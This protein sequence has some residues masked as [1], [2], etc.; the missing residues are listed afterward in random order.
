MSTEPHNPTGATRRQLLRT[1]A[2]GF[3]S[4][5]LSGMLGGKPAAAGSSAS[6]A[7]SQL[8]MFAPRA[9]RV[10]FLFMQGGP[11]QVD[12]FDYKPLL[13]KHH[14]E[15]LSFRDDRKLAK[16]GESGKEIVMRSPWR[17]TRAGESGK[18]VS[19]LFPHVAKCVDQLCFLH[20][21]HTN[22]VAHGPSTLFL[23]TGAID[24]VR[25]SVGS[26]VTYGL[27]SEC[28]NLPGFIT[29]GPPATNGGPRNYGSA[30]L[31]SEYQGAALGRASQPAHEFAFEHMA[32]EPTSSLDRRRRFDLLQSLNQHQVLHNQGDDR[33]DAILR[34]YELAWRMQSEAPDILSLAS[35]SPATLR[36]YGIGEKAT[37]NYGRQCLYARRLAEAGVRYIQV[38]YSDDGANPKWDQHSRI[39]LHEGHARAVDKP[40]AAL[41]TDLRD[42]GLLDDTLVWWGGEFGRNP[43]T[44]GADGRDHNPSGFTHFLA[45]GGVKAGFTHGATD[46]FG[47]EAVAGRVHM[48]D[49]HATILHLL[50]VDHTQLTYEHAGR[51][52]R[53]TDVHGE[54]VH[55]ILA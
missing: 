47:H 38:N 12:T 53:L 44:Q 11:S 36:Q 49:L 6:T 41:I 10:I 50:G 29:I 14:G 52:F 7:R 17:F 33:L 28:D 3:G 23:H 22:G 27:G 24:V 25:P 46:D 45:G 43:F 40:I 19:D 54:V 16:T 1:A 9:K 26:W 31:P 55:E 8:P 42:R 13:A 32:T 20:G 4:V 39:E 15:K 2:C 30:F 37:D 5:A 21:M 48:H 51:P 34:S 35:E 18:Q